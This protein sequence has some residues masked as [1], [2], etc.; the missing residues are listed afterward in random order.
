MT[1]NI[2]VGGTLGEPEQTRPLDPTPPHDGRKDELEAAYLANVHGHGE[3]PPYS[4]VEIRT[5]GELDWIIEQ[6]VWRGEASRHDENRV[7][8]RG[9]ILKG[10][11]LNDVY[12]R[13]AQLD[14]A[15]LFYAGLSGAYL[16]GATF[17]S[18]TLE[19]ADLSG[20]ILERADLR[21]A[22][23]RRAVL[24]NANLVRA[25]LQGANLNRA[26]A[27]NANLTRADLRDADCRDADLRGTVLVGV[28]MDGETNLA[29][30]L[31]D[32]Q[33]KLGG[34]NW[35]DVR[36]AHLRWDHVVSL[37]DE[38]D[39]SHRRNWHKTPRE[40]SVM[41]RKAQRTYHALE[42]ALRQQGLSTIASTYRLGERRM[43]R[44]A[45]YQERRF[46]SWLLSTLLNVIAG[47]GERPRRA[48]FAYLGVI[49]AFMGAYLFVSR[50]EGQEFQ[51]L[52]LHQALILSII[53]F[54]GRGFFEPVPKVGNPISMVAA[55]EAIVGLVI[56]I[57]FI[58]TFTRRFLST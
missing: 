58:V 41:Y 44:K 34:I 42:V 22:V 39:F 46:G 26:K 51:P 8:L 13:N 24:L 29:N 18:A 38:P 2:P 15:D 28:L 11:A 27:G 30:V 53:S 12:L 31:I 57:T 40:R 6:R 4:G 7:D 20:A 56:E 49:L 50:I 17:S 47:Y 3:R 19:R 33:T 54:H 16:E 36:L 1:S 10:T 9:A 45:L 23:L 25:N 5:R 55:L 52:Q 35:A 21:N 37:G 48:V 14:N 43:E 32:N